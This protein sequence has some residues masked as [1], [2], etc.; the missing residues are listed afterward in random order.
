MPNA[1][2]HHAPTLWEETKRPLVRFSSGAT[3]VLILFV[4]VSAPLAFGAVRPWAQGPLMIAVALAT[5]FWIARLV[6]ERETDV[7]FS[8]IGGPALV[9]ATYA[10]VR[11][12]IAEVEP[13]SRPDMMLAITT[14]L[15]FFVVLNTVRHRWQITVLVWTLTATGTALAL[16]GLGQAVSG[17]R[18]VWWF[19]QYDTY[20]G[21]ASGTFI[22]P[23]D[24]AVY[25]HVR[26]E[27]H[28]SEL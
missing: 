20:V 10:I 13:I 12:T 8:P 15:L 7:I 9:L 17:T 2:S 4:M 1:R 14:L 27:E 6:A 26:S 19:P 18:W 24:F 25:L 23:A 28:T 5:M 21:R 3:F 11:Y 16:Y 22:R